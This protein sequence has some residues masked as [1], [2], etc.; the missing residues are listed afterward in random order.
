MIS[1]M[2]DLEWIHRASCL[3]QFEP[4]TPPKYL[5]DIYSELCDCDL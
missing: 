1:A 2:I 5:K 4:V 3:I